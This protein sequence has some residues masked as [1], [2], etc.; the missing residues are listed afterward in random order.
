[1]RE[2]ETTRIDPE[3]GIP[4]LIRQLTDD[5]RRLVSDEV[6]LGKLEMKENVRVG[7]RGA[8]HLAIAFGTGVVAL[9]AVTIFL[10]ALIG[11]AV[12][13]NYWLGALVTGALELAI[14]AVLVRKGLHHFGQP[15]YTLKETRAE[16]GNTAGWVAGRAD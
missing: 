3:V 7:A 9:T 13:G 14:A 5:S 1:M 6:R 2:R 8:L 16:L 11:R 4:D 10:A 12:N 15:S